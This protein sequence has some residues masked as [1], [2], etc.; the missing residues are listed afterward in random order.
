MT[1]RAV[2][3]SIIPVFLF[4]CIR[5]DAFQGD[6]CDV[7]TVTEPCDPDKCLRVWCSEDFTLSCY[8]SIE[9]DWT[10]WTRISVAMNGSGPYVERRVPHHVAWVE[11]EKWPTNDQI[12]QDSG[13]FVHVDHAGTMDFHGVYHPRPHL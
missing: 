7:A 12:C 6:P 3:R 4:A 5:W 10:S 13:E 9:I 1:L 11:S 2:A 8:R